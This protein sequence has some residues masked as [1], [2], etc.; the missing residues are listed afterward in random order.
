MIFVTRTQ[1]L[2]GCALKLKDNDMKVQRYRIR[3]S[4]TEAM[5]FTGHLDLIL[6]WER[7]FRRAGLPLSYSEGF[8]PRPVINLA[9]PLPLGFTSTAELGDFWLSAQ[10]QIGEFTTDLS[11]ALPPGLAINQVEEIADLFGPK[12]PS[13]VESSTYTAVIEAYDPD[14]PGKVT[15][16]LC[17]NQL[18]RTKR[19]K[20]YD[21]R[22][23]IVGIALGDPHDGYQTLQIELVTK[24]DR[25]GRPDEVL[26]ALGYPRDLVRIIRTA[27]QLRSGEKS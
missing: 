2:S 23:L 8:N 4:K 20:E 22:P 15:D 3:F 14:L 12:L 11:S 17:K 5:R 18:T 1:D 10:I 24:P 9:S 21:L 19:G 27:I 7:T 26:D 25:T 6:T 16:L 13:L